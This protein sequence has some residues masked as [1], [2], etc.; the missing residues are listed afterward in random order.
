[1][2]FTMMH[3]A[4]T[5]QAAHSRRCYHQ[6][7]L[8]LHMNQPFSAVGA[9]F[10][11]S[12][13]LTP[14]KGPLSYLSTVTTASNSDWGSQPLQRLS[15]Q[16]SALAQQPSGLVQ[17]PSLA[18]A[19]LQQQQPTATSAALQQ[20]KPSSGSHRGTQQMQ[21]PATSM[22][23]KA[24]AA[25]MPH[26]MNNRAEAR[27]ASKAAFATPSDAQADS[28]L[29]NQAQGDAQGSTW[30]AGGAE[31]GAFDNHPNMI[32]SA[33][34]QDSHI[35][36]Y[37]RSSLSNALPAS[38]ADSS[39][40]PAAQDWSAF[41]QNSEPQAQPSAALYRADE[42]IQASS[43]NLQQ[44]PFEASFPD[45]ERQG[46]T[47]EAQQHTADLGSAFGADF[48]NA[49]WPASQA[50]QQQDTAGSGPSFDAEAS[51]SQWQVSQQHDAGLA[52]MGSGDSFGDFNTSGEHAG[53][54]VEDWAA[55]PAMPADPF[56]ASASFK[57]FAALLEP[58]VPAAV[59]PDLDA[60]GDQQQP[61]LQEV[62]LTE[63]RSS[64]T[65]GVQE[66][67]KLPFP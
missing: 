38:Q 5:A 56:A 25:A 36:A 65:L 7:T 42:R 59:N 8:A 41:G 54:E 49:Q 6:I 3:P 24:D 28:A 43:S 67:S 15:P 55:A 40:Q 46:S 21:Q 50:S 57:D 12:A 26:D 23:H 14:Q 39:Q 66:Q 63:L 62:D 20:S 11:T 31:W 30:A 10:V 53:G 17:Q 1:M 34:T 4:D 52:H 22:Q 48:S 13:Q 33:N 58:N 64:G 18:T 45:Y 29:P 2:T 9:N 61:P 19:S 60:H 35:D 27:Q 37:N 47:H 16:P 51:T 44:P 32:S